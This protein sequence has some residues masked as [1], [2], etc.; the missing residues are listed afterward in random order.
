MAGSQKIKVLV[1]RKGSGRDLLLYYVDPVTGRE[2]SKTSGTGDVE[3]AH[4][5]AARWEDELLDRRGQDGDGWNHFLDRFNEEYLI[6]LAPDSRRS[7]RTALNR[8]RDFM[9][10]STLADISASSMS[11]FRAK[12]IESDYRPAS[13]ANFLTHVKSALGWAKSV[14][15]IREVPAVKMP[16]QGRQTFMRGRPISKA[17]Y[18]RMLEAC[19]KPEYRRL[20]ELLWLSGLRLGEALRLSWDR[21]PILVD[22]DGGDY[23]QMIFYAE[24]HKSRRDEAVPLTPE[25]YSWLRKTPEKRRQGLVAPVPL[26]LQRNVSKLIGQCG[27]A[28]DVIVSDDGKFASAHDF[29]RSFGTRWAQIVL[30]SILQKLMRHADIQTTLRYYV[31]ISA[32]DAGRALWGESRSKISGGDKKPVPKNVP[33]SK[34]GRRKAG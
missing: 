9:A 28:A 11:Q 20:M 17:E 24:G 15:M 16:R 6:D 23:P 10:P 1:R 21:P 4:K 29:R 19:D 34:T 7:Y 3:E 2:V 14:G 33:K 12:L 22:L 8:Y 30:P 27:E 32:A 25:L 18:L 26:V 5:A 31:G 13:V